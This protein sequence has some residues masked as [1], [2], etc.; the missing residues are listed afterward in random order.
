MN[1]PLLLCTDLDRTLLPNGVQPESPGARER[2]AGLARE[3]GI[4][5]VY[6][7]GRHRELVQ[8]AISSYRLPQPAYAITDVGTRIYRI[9]DGDWQPWPEWEQE[10]DGDWGGLGHAEL[11][12]LFRDLPDLQ[13]QEVSKQNTHKLSFYVPLYADRE[14]LQAVMQ[15]RLAEH[16]VR[17]SLIW[18]IDEPAAIGL[19]DVLPERATKL[20]AIE[21]LAGKLG[22]PRQATL[23]AGDSGNDLPVLASALPSVLVANA[24]PE[25]RE[26]ARAQA[27]M[28][29]HGDALYVARGGFLGMNGNY[30]AGILEGLAHFHPGL[31]TG[32][33]ETG[34]A[35]AS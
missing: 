19:L 33:A 29:G 27:E 32:L 20:H 30:S 6:V 17:A 10:I 5:L 12:E 15:V 2:F 25:V 21:F 24:S 8:N 13:L 7:T 35:A 23:F 22:I 9:S 31:A 3:P 1:E 14:A 28:A 4:T 11:R 16:G 26:A 18:S 34:G